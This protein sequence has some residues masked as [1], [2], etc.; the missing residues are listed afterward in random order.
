MSFKRGFIPRPARRAI[1]PLRSTLGGV[2]RRAT[3]K[4]VRS[5]LYVAHP[6]GTATTWL[7]RAVRKSL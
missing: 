7:G 6:K 2:K 3:P 4:A 5:A 1:H